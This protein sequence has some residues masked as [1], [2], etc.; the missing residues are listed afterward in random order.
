MH[1]ILFVLT[2]LGILAAPGPTNALLA[3]AGARLGW[4]TGAWLASAPA[5]GYLAGVLA[6]RL[7]TQR[8]EMI[9]PM[10]SLGL[11][12][13]VALYLL[14]LAVRLWRQG[15]M[16]RERRQERAH[17]TA[18]EVAL[19]TLLN[20]KCFIFAFSIIPFDAPD[21]AAYLLGFMVMVIG[22]SLAWIAAGAWLGRLT[23]RQGQSRL[24]PRLSALVVGVFALLLVVLPLVR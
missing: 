17:I 15:D 14:L 19:T 12:L 24:V 13:A 6:L 2:A 1:V 22:V 8:L 11:R 3:T 4:A 20:P 21:S 16:R 23:E 5:L 7:L 18:W 9:S 10:V